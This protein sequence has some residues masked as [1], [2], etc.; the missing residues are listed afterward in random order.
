MLINSKVIINLT[1]EYPMKSIDCHK[2]NTLYELHC[3]KSILKWQAK[4]NLFY[5]VNV[6]QFINR[7]MFLLWFIKFK[8]MYLLFSFKFLNHNKNNTRFINWYNFNSSKGI[9][10]LKLGSFLLLWFIKFHE[11]LNSL[12]FSITTK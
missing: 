7:V 11:T 4:S 6:S 5:K 10:V 2:W 12:F 8:N 3:K 9:P 1:N